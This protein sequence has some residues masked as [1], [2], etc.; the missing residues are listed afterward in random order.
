MSESKFVPNT[1]YV[2]VRAATSRLCR[3][4]NVDARCEAR[5]A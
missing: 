1:V 2:A 3:C 5:A 4:T